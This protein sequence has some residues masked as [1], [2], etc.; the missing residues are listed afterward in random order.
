VTYQP[1]FLH[2]VKPGVFFL[3]HRLR[4]EVRAMFC[5]MSSRMP[6]G[7][8]E[9]RY[10]Q[11]VD[12][13]AE[14]L[15]KTTMEWGGR[16]GEEFPVN[17]VARERAELRLC[18][19]PLHPKVQTFFDQFVLRY[20]HSSIMELTGSPSVYVQGVSYWAAMKS[21]GNPQVSG[22]EFSTRTVRH[23]DWPMAR[24]CFD[25][26]KPDD[27]VTELV[28][29][30][31]GETIGFWHPNPV[32]KSLHDG[33]FELFEA[34][35][36]A[37]KDHLTD[38]VNRAA[39][40]IADKEPFRPALDRARCCI[41]GT[42]STGFAHTANLRTM[43]RVIQDGQKLA[44]A[45][46]APAVLKVWDDIAQGY[47]AA[48][49]GLAEMGLREAVYTSPADLD[50]H[51]GVFGVYQEDAPDDVSVKFHLLKNSIPPHVRTRQSSE[52]TYLDPWF[53]HFARVDIS[54]Q[55]SL[56]VSRDWHRH[57]TMMPWFLEIV[58]D[59]DLIQLHHKY[60][61]KSDYARSNHERMLRESTEAYRAFMKA[62]DEYR[63]MLCL[64]LGTKVQMSGQAGL[65]DA[66]YM[67]ELRRDAHGA[68][69][70][71]Q[72]QANRAM[73]QLTA[74]IQATEILGGT[75]I[76]INAAKVM[77]LVG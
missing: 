72:D 47:A 70:E 67:L 29:E 48:I 55:C 39:L 18:D 33:W 14:D 65:R 3:D 68:N 13:V 43:A 61:L 35:V 54:F 9:A 19:T 12:A 27:G 53:N 52:K 56:A 75:P 17:K 60:E 45:S 64:P 40:G 58:W 57:R 44:K 46:G 16:E 25:L 76:P 62:G 8:I 51:L 66:V 37:W 2:Q 50:M 5:A 7:G 34:E 23:K 42:I 1:Q 4:P 21:F 31:G 32:L 73:E 59:G 30:L 77:G 69:F 74:Q 10:M 20:G 63:A 11:I 38:P 26:H 15:I 28:E 36:D 6:L 49:P 41:P 22:Q 24:E 71:Y